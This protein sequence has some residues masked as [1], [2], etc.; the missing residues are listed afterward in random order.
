MN[1]ISLVSFA[2]LV[3]FMPWCEIFRILTRFPSRNAL[4]EIWIFPEQTKSHF[5][6]ISWRRLN[7]YRLGFRVL[8]KS[9]LPEMISLGLSEKKFCLTW[10]SVQEET[11]ANSINFYW[12]IFS[13]TAF[14][15]YQSPYPLHMYI[16]WVSS[17]TN[18]HIKISVLLL[19]RRAGSL[20]CSSLYFR[21]GHLNPPPGVAT[22]HCPAHLP[23]N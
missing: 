16:W 17:S 7:A 12:T 2:F 1:T 4:Q 20:S 6:F 11:F 23:P 13:M 22:C 10:F 8:S 3:L 15:F 9:F 19:Y 21:F 5:W 14:A 18:V